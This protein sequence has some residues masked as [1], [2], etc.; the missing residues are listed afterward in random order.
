VRVLV[1]AN[2]LLDVA[3]DRGEFVTESKQVVAWC[4]ETTGSAVMAWHTV[5]NVYYVLR[6]ARNDRF[7]RRFI[8]DMLRFGDIAGGDGEAIRRALALAM[9]DFEDAL[10]VAAAM[11][12]HAQWI[13]TRNATDYRGSPLPAITPRDFIRRF[14]ST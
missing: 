3:L 8:S 4:Q 12:A 10:Q 9:S 11:S 6:G 14:I 5:S 7:A 2:V 1:D 13:V